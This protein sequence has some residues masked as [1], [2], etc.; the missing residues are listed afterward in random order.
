MQPRTPK[1]SRCPACRPQHLRFGG[2]YIKDERDG[3]CMVCKNTR[4]VD[5][6]VA[7]RFVAISNRTLTP[8]ICPVKSNLF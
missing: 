8:R 5:T 6:E 3:L 4:Q 2:L 1:T 7:A